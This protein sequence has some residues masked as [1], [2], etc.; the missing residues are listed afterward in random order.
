MIRL[1]D[2]DTCWT[3]S[4]RSPEGREQRSGRRRL[5]FPRRCA[6]G[7]RDC[8][9]P[10]PDWR[11]ATSVAAVPGAAPGAFDRWEPDV[12]PESLSC[13]RSIPGALSQLG[14]CPPHKIP[15]SAEAPGM[16][17]RL[18]L[19]QLLGQRGVAAIQALVVLVAARE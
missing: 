16:Q 15:Q 5:P 9:L 3:S 1:L 17:R 11:F 2:A 19:L 10:A 6:P 14:E 18:C 13:A 8:R 7:I 4:D 12:F